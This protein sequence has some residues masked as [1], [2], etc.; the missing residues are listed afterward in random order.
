MSEKQ[1]GAFLMPRKYSKEEKEEYLKKYYES[2]QSKLSFARN[3]AIPKT[4]FFSWFKSSKK[5]PKITTDI[6]FGKINLEGQL[7]ESFS[8]QIKIICNKIEILIPKNVNKQDLYNVMEV[9]NSINDK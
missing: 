9:I 8:D 4:T 3:N 2:K 7:N 5:V 1:G 6:E